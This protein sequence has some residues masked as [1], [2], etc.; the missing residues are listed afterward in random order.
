MAG[1]S[2][3][4]A[5]QGCWVEHFPSVSET[6]SLFLLAAA[7]MNA[8][9]RMDEKI[10]S[11]LQLYY[12]VLEY[13]LM[14]HNAIYSKHTWSGDTSSFLSRGCRLNNLQINIY[15]KEKKISSC[16]KVEKPLQ[17]WDTA[18]QT[19][20][21]LSVEKCNLHS[22]FKNWLSLDS[23]RFTEMILDFKLDDNVFPCYKMQFESKTLVW[24]T[25]GDMD[26]VKEN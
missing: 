6:V 8:D 2:V 14:V 3:H 11:F 5:G 4:S 9:R 23:V 20:L 17:F 16:L 24:K 26:S 1:V 18:T 7:W 10:N 25:V 12:S 22:C 13:H 19:L 15:L 21:I